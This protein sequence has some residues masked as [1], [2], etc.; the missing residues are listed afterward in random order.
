MQ[1][2]VTLELPGPPGA[3]RF[4]MG[5]GRPG[6]RSAGER[7]AAAAAAAASAAAAS[8]ATVGSPPTVNNNAIII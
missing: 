5:L 3:V 2:Q 6:H 8:A 1:E 7:A 4:C